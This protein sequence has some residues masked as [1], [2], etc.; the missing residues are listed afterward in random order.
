MNEGEGKVT[1]PACR[2]LAFNGPMIDVGAA[3][4]EHRG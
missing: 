3:G 2:G 4:E 1:P